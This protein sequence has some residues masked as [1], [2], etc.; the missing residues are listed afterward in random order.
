MTRWKGMVT[1]VIKASASGY[2]CSL[3]IPKDPFPSYPCCPVPANTQQHAFCSLPRCRAPSAAHR[4]PV[5][6]CPEAGDELRVGRR[7][8]PPERRQCTHLRLRVLVLRAG[9]GSAR[10]VPRPLATPLLPVTARCLSLP[11]GPPLMF[12]IGL[13]GHVH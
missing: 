12:H 9:C 6:R 7:S 5:L 13:Y 1:L 3:D 8:F 11:L 4:G 10:S 2:H